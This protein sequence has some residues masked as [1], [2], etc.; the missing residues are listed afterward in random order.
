MKGLLRVS[1]MLALGIG[2]YLLWAAYSM[3]TTVKRDGGPERIQ[4]LGLMQEQQNGMILGGV[5]AVVGVVV[6]A[7]GEIG[8][9]SK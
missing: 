5:V 6:F 3:D 2:L 8:A 1:G 7:A 4:N 9:K